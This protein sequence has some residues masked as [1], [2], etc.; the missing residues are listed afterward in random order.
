MKYA[1]SRFKIGDV[2]RDK[3]SKQVFPVADVEHDM[4]GWKYWRLISEMWNIAYFECDLELVEAVKESDVSAAKVRR[5]KSKAMR[6]GG[7]S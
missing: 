7:N 6:A 2:V 4:S 1:N 3:Q 5:G